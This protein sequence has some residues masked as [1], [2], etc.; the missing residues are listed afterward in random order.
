MVNMD[1]TIIRN[2][3]QLLNHATAILD[4]QAI[5]KPFDRQVYN[6]YGP[7]SQEDID[8]FRPLFNC[9]IQ[10]KWVLFGGFKGIIPV[11]AS[12]PL[13]I[14]T[15]RVSP[16]LDPAIERDKPDSNYEKP[17]AYDE[18]PPVKPREPLSYIIIVQ[19]SNASERSKVV[20]NSS[21]EA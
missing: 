18:E 16:G 4:E 19:G 15:M 20:I 21:L 11:E 1:Q 8:R 12:P 2:A 13:G 14:P 6:Q 3:F 7:I 5:I 9:G 10:D 17:P